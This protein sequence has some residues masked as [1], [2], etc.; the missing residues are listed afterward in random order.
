M[1]TQEIANRLVELC[2]QGQYEAAQTELYADNAI[3]I[4]SPGNPG[5]E[6]V[7]SLE[8]IIQKGKQFQE[9]TE[10]FYGGS[11]SDPVVADNFFS[12]AMMI[13]SKMKGM[14]RM[15]ME[16]ICL[17]EVKDG[18]IVREQFFYTPGAPPQ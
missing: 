13:D 8:A 9:M 11:V 2:R 3:S 10:E 6:R 14:P 16:E 17:Y 7:E 4:E 5:P 15:K 18:K 1:T 12:C